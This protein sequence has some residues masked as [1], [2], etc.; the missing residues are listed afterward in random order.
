MQVFN[1]PFRITKNEDG[2]F[3][4]AIAV[5]DTILIV[6]TVTSAQLLQLQMDVEQV[7]KG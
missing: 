5:S 7:L 2:S 6:K 3:T 4:I 1:E